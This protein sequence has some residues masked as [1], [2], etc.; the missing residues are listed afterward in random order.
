MPNPFVPIDP[1]DPKLE[2]FEGPI[3]PDGKIR[4]GWRQVPNSELEDDPRWTPSTPANTEDDAPSG[5]PLD[6]RS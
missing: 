2:G 6:P 4:P 5:K 1:K 3:G